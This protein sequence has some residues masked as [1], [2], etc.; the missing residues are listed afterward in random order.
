[1]RPIGVFDSGIG[2]LTVV[3]EIFRVLPEE[4]VLFFGDTARLPYGPK[5]AETVTRFS[6][7]I[8]RFLLARDVRCV[9]V[10]CNTASSAALPVLERESPVPVLG[11]IAPGARAAARETRSGV[12]GVIGTRGTVASGAYERALRAIDPALRVV[13]EACPLLVPLV[14]EG[15]VDHP[16]TEQVVRQYLD[17]LLRR[18]IDTLI[19][20]C[21][22]FPV[23]RGVI[24]KVAGEGVV[25]VD[26]ARETACALREALPPQAR[27]PKGAPSH[28][29]LVTDV[30]HRFREEAELFLGAP[31][32]RVERV[33]TEQLEG[34]CRE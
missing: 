9:V 19:L 34:V 15:W 31:V 21:T 29:F 5:S 14:E 10:A 11:V 33:E 6:R 13:S 28:R 30:P 32:E 12:I 1:M 24:G 16:V 20:G 27:A 25:I 7:Q 4:P 3:R 22:H 17:P 23:L 18:S 2:G 8:T 26:A